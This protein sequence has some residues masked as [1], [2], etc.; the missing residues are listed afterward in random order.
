[1]K[2]IGWTVSNETGPREASEGPVS[3]KE[4][5]TQHA[6]SFF[7]IFSNCH[8]SLP[9]DEEWDQTIFALLKKKNPNL[10]LNSHGSFPLHLISA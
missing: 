9:A 5:C 7:H 8:L 6:T 3:M 1:M 10:G 2:H 4:F